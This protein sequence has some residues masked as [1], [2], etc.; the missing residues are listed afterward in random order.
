LFAQFAEPEMSSR[1]GI[2]T[3]PS[4]GLVGCATIQNA[5]SWTLAKRL[6]AR[7]ARPM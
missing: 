7:S 5:T 2:L 4:N 6:I 1:R 3:L